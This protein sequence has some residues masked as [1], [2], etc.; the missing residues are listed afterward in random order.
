MPSAAVS[1]DAD[2]FTRPQEHGLVEPLARWLGD[3]ADAG[4]PVVVREDHVDLVGAVAE[5][6]EV[7]L[8]FD[9]HMDLSLEFLLGAP[10]AAP[11]DATVF[12]TV[13]ATDV[14][15]R[16]VWVHPRSRRAV[17]AR[18]YAAAVLTARQPLLS[19]IHCLPGS[20]GLAR[21]DG[22]SVRWAFVCRSP[23]YAT[24]ASDAAFARLAGVAVGARP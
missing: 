23:G 5:P 3:R 22:L 10:P 6:V 19:R 9:F 13:L 2:F 11:S 17:A 14:T 7:M 21:L 12:E 18:V 16:Y 20:E 24:E 15:R 4:M 1:I 8:N